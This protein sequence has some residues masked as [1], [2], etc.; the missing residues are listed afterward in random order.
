[1]TNRT[2]AVGRIEVKSYVPTP[3]DELDGGP[4][5]VAIDVTETFTGDIQGEGAARFL[6]AMNADGSASFCGIERVKGQIGKRQGT[7]LLQDEGTVK[8]KTVSGTW[9]VIP[10]SGTG[11]LKGLRGEG[12]FSADLGQNATIHLDYWFEG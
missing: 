12:G 10:G 1:V 9:F 7:F 3:Y 5:L 11:D 6:Q 8:G 4:K 2:K